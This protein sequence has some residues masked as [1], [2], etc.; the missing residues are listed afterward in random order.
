MSELYHQLEGPIKSVCWRQMGRVALPYK[1]ASLPLPSGQFSIMLLFLTLLQPGECGANISLIIRE[2]ELLVSVYHYG[3]MAAKHA[4]RSLGSPNP[5]R[6][7]NGVRTKKEQKPPVWGRRKKSDY[8]VRGSPIHSS[9]NLSLMR[10][11]KNSTQ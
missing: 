11:P 7:R 2:P 1:G 4:L 3:D 5:Q 10:C 8:K 9:Q 6:R